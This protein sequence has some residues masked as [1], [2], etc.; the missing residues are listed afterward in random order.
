MTLDYFNEIAFGLEYENDTKERNPTLKKWEK[1]GVD[2]ALK[3]NKLDPYLTNCLENVITDFNSLSATTKLKVGDESDID[4]YLIPVEEFSTLIPKYTPGNYGYFYLE[5]NENNE[6]SH[7]T[8]LI[9]SN[10][11]SKDVERCHLIREEL[12]Q[13]M[14]LPKDSDKYE[15]SIFYGP[16]T[17]VLS[18]SQLDKELIELLYSGKL[19]SG[20][21][22]QEINNS[23]I[24]D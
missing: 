10:D 8:I 12:T 18:Y 9:N 2:I 21:T 24:I 11:P 4:L 23:F 6:I 20:M 1:S 15:D 5:F 7:S 17:T 3:G 13:S 22:K 19:K 16:W 14:G